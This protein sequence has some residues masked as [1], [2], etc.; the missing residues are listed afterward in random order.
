MMKITLI[1]AREILKGQRWG[2][3]YIVIYFLHTMPI[4]LLLCVDGLEINYLFI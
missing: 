4:V 3:T 2:L 1:S